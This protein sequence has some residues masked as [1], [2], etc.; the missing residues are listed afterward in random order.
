MYLH[1]PVGNARTW[2]S[3]MFDG[4]PFATE[5]KRVVPAMKQ[6][7][8]AARSVDPAECT[9]PL[10]RKALRPRTLR[11]VG[12][13][14]LS[15]RAAAP[16]ASVRRITSRWQRQSE[17]SASNPSHGDRRRSADFL[18]SWQKDSASGSPNRQSIFAGGHHPEQGV[19]GWQSCS[20]RRIFLRGQG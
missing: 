15:S 17:G 10:S 7:V 4:S 3:S 12:T 8:T 16:T 11:R 5:L 9:L 20:W 19:D 13:I 14:R 18:P 2:P 6:L 1:S